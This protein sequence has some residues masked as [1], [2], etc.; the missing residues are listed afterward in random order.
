LDI[1]RYI[2]P[3]PY[4]WIFLDSISIPWIYPWIFVDI[5][6]MILSPF[7]GMVLSVDEE[8]CTF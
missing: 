5:D 2:F 4:P 8:Y 1:S 6:H 7:L 3:Y